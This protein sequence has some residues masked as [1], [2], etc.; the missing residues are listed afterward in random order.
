MAP[1]AIPSGNAALAGYLPGTTGA[2]AFFDNLMPST[3]ESRYADAATY[4]AVCRAV[5]ARMC[6][7]GAGESA[8]EYPIPE[9]L[10]RAPA[11]QMV[12][13]EGIDGWT[14]ETHSTPA[15]TPQGATLDDKACY[16]T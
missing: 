8:S 14:D 9:R 3:R 16:T 7:R 2:K 10:D 15:N 1:Q 6:A 4:E 13:L 11:R 12:P 5:Q